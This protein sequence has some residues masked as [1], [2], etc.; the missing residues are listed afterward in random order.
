MPAE[1]PSRLQR[2]Q[3]MLVR[4]SQLTQQKGGHRL[5]LVIFAAKAKLVCPLTHDYDHFREVVLKYDLKHLDPSIWPDKNDVSGTRIGTGL[6]QAVEAHDQGDSETQSILL[7]S[8]GDDPVNEDDWRFIGVPDATHRAIPIH[9]VGIGD[10]L[11]QTIPA[12]KFNSQPVKTKLNE[13]PLQ[14][15][16]ERTG[17]VYIHAGRSEID[18]DAIFRLTLSSGG[19]RDKGVDRLPVY[20]QQFAWFL[21]PAFVL[22]LGAIAIRGKLR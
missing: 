8:D 1:Q 13:E 15:I 16:A 20:R 12:A 11:E 17:G 14:D 6:L 7:L 18:A 9:C 4:L 5:A 10:E 3:R 19:L 22:L 2:A 21:T